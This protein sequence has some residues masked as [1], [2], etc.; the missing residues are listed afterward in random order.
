MFVGFFNFIKTPSNVFASSN[1]IEINSLNDFF[2]IKNNPN[3][4]YVLNCD[5]D[6][7]YKGTTYEPFEFFGTLDGNYHTLK[8]LNLITNSKS[9]GLFKKLDGVL[10]ENLS[11]ENFQIY[12]LDSGCAGA[13]AGEINN[14]TVT[15]LNIVFAEY[16]YIFAGTAGLVA[17]KIFNSNINKVYTLNGIING[18]K[19]QKLAAELI[20]TNVVCSDNKITDPNISVDEDTDNKG[21]SSTDNGDDNNVGDVENPTKPSEPSTPIENDKPIID[22]PIKDDNKTEIDSTDNTTDNGEADNNTDEIVDNNNVVVDNEENNNSDINVDN[23]SSNNSGSKIQNKSKLST[24]L[25]STLIP[26]GVILCASFTFIFVKL[27]RKK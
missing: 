24:I 11:L 5:L 27:K 22:N 20:E 17:G 21:D 9:A 1:L 23:S 15:N 12:G 16:N 18:T 19:S 10:I 4:N 2:N 6:F 25:L 26:A 8:N 7:C 14:S 13:L 3:G